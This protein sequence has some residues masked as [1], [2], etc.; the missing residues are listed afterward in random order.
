[1]KTRRTAIN[2]GR[3][4]PIKELFHFVKRDVQGCIAMYII[5]EYQAELR[6]TSSESSWG[7]GANLVNPAAFKPRILPLKTGWGKGRKSVAIPNQIREGVEVQ[8]P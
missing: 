6:E 2:K 7:H 5:K 8:D 3:T 1:M 4:K